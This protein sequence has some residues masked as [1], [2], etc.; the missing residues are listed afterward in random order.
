MGMKLRQRGRC[1]RLHIRYVRRFD[2]WKLRELADEH[3][4]KLFAAIFGDL[5][6]CQCPIRLAKS[7]FCVV[8]GKRNRKAMG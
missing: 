1:C 2:Y 4:Q 8:D 3:L 5:L 7:N 6:H